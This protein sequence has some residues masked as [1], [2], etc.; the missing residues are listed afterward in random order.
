MRP[1]PSAGPTRPSPKSATSALRRS[2]ARST[3]SAPAGDDEDELE[4]L[5][6]PTPVSDRPARRTPRPPQ[7][8]EMA[9]EMVEIVSESP[10]HAPGSGRRSRVSRVSEIAAGSGTALQRAVLAE[11]RLDEE[12]EI[13]GEVEMSFL[14]GG[15]AVGVASSPLVRKAERNRSR[16]VAGA[17]DEGFGKRGVR[18]RDVRRGEV[19]ELSPAPGRVEKRSAAKMRTARLSRESG[20]GEVDELSPAPLRVDGRNALRTRSV[21]G[22][23][24]GMD[25]VDELSPAPGRV[26]RRSATKM[27]T[28]RLSRES[29]DG[30]VDELSPDKGGVS[31]A[32]PSSAKKKLQA[33]AAKLKPKLD[34]PSTSKTQAAKPVKPESPI[35]AQNNQRTKKPKGRPANVRQVEGPEEPEEA[36]EI[37]E[38]EAARRLGRKRPRRSISSPLVEAE[39]ESDIVA[40]EAAPAAKRRR[41]EKALQSPV[42]QQRPKTRKEKKQAEQTKKP[43]ATKKKG[44]TG[45]KAPVDEDEDELQGGT[46]PVI[47]QRFTKKVRIDADDGAADV[48]SSDLIP[49]ANR[50]G[51]N[52]VDVLA[53]MCDEMVDSFLS[54]LY[55]QTREAADP[56]VKREYR[57]MIRALD[58]F[59]EQ[60][61]TRLLGHTIALDDLHAL[62]KRVRVAQR[63]KLALREEILKIRAER[64]QLALRM[65]AVRIK[66]EERSKEALVCLPL[67]S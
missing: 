65:D 21:T 56:A 1:Q 5:P 26:D 6:R 12:D 39:E 58:L 62:Q 34:K 13:T 50:G 9:E 3:P 15:V 22:R 11:R 60:L 10:A 48:L 41:K 63:D 44:K 20:D 29:G 61:S 17:A 27:R 38:N 8:A 4:S 66:H 42:A 45:T 43:P 67:L 31:V 35:P 14:G 32:A 55:G 16:R 28:A 36:E 40:E 2:I 25:E 46:I 64:E 23:N 51:V 37:D 49:F 57:T 59:R 52:V 53:Q 33:E 7:P 18:G 47:V 54:K 24:L 30:E 19:D